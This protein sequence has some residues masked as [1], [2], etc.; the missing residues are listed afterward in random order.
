VGESR[1]GVH[2]Q[3]D[4]APGVAEVFGDRGGGEGCPH[5]HERRFVARGDDHHRAGQ[6]VGS[7][8]VLEE[9]LDFA[10]ALS[11]Q[12]DHIHSRG[13]VACDR[14]QER[15]LSD[16]R[17]GEDAHPLATPQRCKEV[18]GAYAGVQRLCNSAARERGDR[19]RVDRARVGVV[20][21]TQA[22]D[23]VAQPVHAPAQQAI[24]HRDGLGHLQ[25]DDAVAGADARCT[26]EH[27]DNRVRAAETDDLTHQAR[28]AGG[29]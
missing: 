27:H 15:G 7:E 11:D 1:D 8:V 9:V 20:E 25:A 5:A 21:R 22:V 19:R 28:R 29:S 17:P 6:T 4:G 12:G 24:T 2:Y 10:A 26:R 23:R 18:Y 14:A 3:K 13:C 16:A